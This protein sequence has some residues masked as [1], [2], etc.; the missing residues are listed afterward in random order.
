MKTK[1]KKNL[2]AFEKSSEAAE[3]EK[4]FNWV[5]IHQNLEQYPGLYLLYHIPNEGKRSRYAGGKLKLQ[6][7]KKGTSD[8]C[9]PVARGKYH[10]LYFEMKYGNNKLTK[11]QKKFLRGVKEQGYATWV[12]YSAEEAIGLIKAYYHLK[13]EV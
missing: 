12:C 7:L 11:E 4:L 10:G 8:V 3:Q 9:L 2:A 5:E 13:R 1:S 6:G